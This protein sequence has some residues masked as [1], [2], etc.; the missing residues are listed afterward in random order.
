MRPRSENPLLACPRPARGGAPTG[1]VR[2]ASPRLEMVRCTGQ[3]ARR[4][5]TA[6]RASQG[7][8]ARRAPGQSDWRD[9]NVSDLTGLKFRQFQ[10]E[11][12]RLGV[13]FLVAPEHREQVQFSG[14]SG[15]LED[16][17]TG[18]T[19]LDLS[20]GGLALVC[21]QFVP[22]MCEGTI[23]IFRT[24]EAPSE[25]QGPDQAVFEHP[26]RVRRVSLASHDPTYELGVAF[27]DPGPD[28]EDRIAALKKFALQGDARGDG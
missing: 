20:A 24:T 26:V 7:C 4:A 19:T 14:T 16:F 2:R 23:R 22:R 1:P 27:I 6:P 8:P 12:V 18:G 13:A 21:P 28:V 9:Q 25:L 15:A 10:R 3:S 11:P 17:A 5:A